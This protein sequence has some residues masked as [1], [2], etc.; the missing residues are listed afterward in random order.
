MSR[1]KRFDHNKIKKKRG[2]FIWGILYHAYNQP[3]TWKDVRDKKPWNKPSSSFKRSRKKHRRNQEKQV[4]REGM[5]TDMEH[6]VFPRFRK[7]D[8]W[9]WL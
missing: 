3:S 8:E 2:D 6:I 5:Q 9:D 7:C 4:F 1:T